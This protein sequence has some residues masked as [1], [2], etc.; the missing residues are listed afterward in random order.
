MLRG[1]IVALEVLLHCVAGFLFALEL[2]RADIPS[3]WV[4]E[5]LFLLAA[6]LVTSLGV[7]FARRGRT[8]IALL[9]VQLGLLVL[10]GIPEGASL[11]VE[12]VLSLLLVVESMLLLRTGRNLGF[13]AVAVVLMVAIQ[14]ADISFVTPGARPSPSSLV[15]FAVILALACALAAALSAVTRRLETQ[16]E[17]VGRLDETIARLVEA[18]IGFQRYAKEVEGESVSMERKRVSREIHDTIGYTITT[19][20]MLMEAASD[21]AEDGKQELKALLK[22]GIDQAIFSLDEIRRSLRELRAMEVPQRHG[23]RAIKKMI[24]TFA[25]ATRMQVSVDFTNV[26]WNFDEEGDEV[27]YRMIQESLANAFRHG[28]ATRVAVVFGQTDH[29]VQVSIWDNG[30][31]SAEI[32]EGIGLSGMRERIERLNGRLYAQSLA[33]GFKLMAVVPVA[34]GEPPNER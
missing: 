24:Q 1:A 2:P 8:R 11:G 16:N 17:L 22:H 20:I 31:G 10:M 4:G 27:F 23:L 5:F 29:N 25:E 32:H 12:T 7:V 6:S 15:L 26:V 3:S 14:L 33:D 28:N 19:L 13:S 34:D 9:A 18:N 30:K 21:L